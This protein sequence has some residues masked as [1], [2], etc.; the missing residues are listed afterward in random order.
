MRLAQLPDHDSPR[1]ERDGEFKNLGF[2]AEEYEGMLVFLEDACFA[3]A[4]AQKSNVSAVIAT[5]AL[6]GAVCPGVALATSESPRLA[7]ARLHNRLA[8]SGFY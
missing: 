4:L 1:I 5:E 3:G 8:A 2:L 6:S 7:F